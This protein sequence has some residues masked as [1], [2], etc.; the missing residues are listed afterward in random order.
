M[1]KY[2]QALL[3]SP[4]ESH[5]ENLVQPSRTGKLT[6]FIKW[7]GGKEQE[8]KHI[9]PLVPSFRD[10][11]EPFV[12]GGAVFF[13]IQAKG[14]F[15][16]DRSSE[17]FNLYTMIDQHN[18]D[19]FDA[20]DTLLAGW[21]QISE[22]VDKSASDLIVLYK[23]YSFDRDS[24][25]TMKKKLLE[26]ISYHA[27]E[28][29]KMFMV[30]YNQDIE[31]FFRELQRNLFSKT[32]RM[33]ELEHKKW[34]LPEQDILANIESALKSAYYMHMRYLYNNINNYQIPSPLASAIF[35]F[36]RENA[37]ASM[38]RYNSRGEFN[39][40][41]GGLSYNRK[42]LVRKISYMRSDEL[43]FHFRNTVIE[44][45]DFETFL[46]KYTPQEND[47]IF[48]DPPYDS[49]FSTYAQNEFSMQDQERLASYLQK[50]CKARFML[51]VKNTPA[52]FKLYDQKGLTI[53]MFDKKYLVSFQDRNNKDTEHLIITNYEIE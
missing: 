20:L 38:F 17:L 33:K 41:Y 39:V 25:D 28:F 43:R 9:L 16:N 22:I 27:E 49:E 42:D 24:A 7:A 50:H 29:R 52:I 23:A 36:V 26:F 11:Y 15:I 45:L 46:L 37:Y 21:Q 1:L 3:W 34:K 40:P 19:F 51:V 31:N 18:A 2:D 48:L 53:R 12:G 6:S 47:F 13:A 14:K 32:S 10:Y 4:I 35:F 30:V 44:N 5:V 8:L